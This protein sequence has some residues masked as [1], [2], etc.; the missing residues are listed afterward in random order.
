MMF[1]VVWSVEALRQLAQIEGQAD[2]PGRIRQAAEWVDYALRRMP[3][4]L[5]ESREK[6]ERLWYGDVLGVFFAVDDDARRV[7]VKSVAPSRRR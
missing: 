6:P 5:G 2:D 1:A 7:R 3:H 4:D